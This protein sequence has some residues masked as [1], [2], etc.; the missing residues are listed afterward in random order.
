MELHRPDR[1]VGHSDGFPL[2]SVLPHSPEN[3]QSL[4][5]LHCPDQNPPKGAT[6]TAKTR[7]DNNDVPHHLCGL[8]HQCIDTRCPC[9]GPTRP[10]KPGVF[11][12]LLWRGSI[13]HL[14][15]DDLSKQRFQPFYLRAIG[16]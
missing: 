8:P 5:I 6:E 14:P 2:Y 1:D 12:G 10:T 9:A 13:L 3:S 4:Q 11:H 16:R 7:E 15:V